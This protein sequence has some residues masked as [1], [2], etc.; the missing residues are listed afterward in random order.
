MSNIKYFQKFVVKKEDEMLK[1]NL[2]LWSYT[3]VS[4]KDQYDKNSSVERQKEAN[5]AY[6][7][8]NSYEIT[9]EFGGTYESGKSDF[10]RKEFS[11]LIEKV[12]SS[13]KRPF[14][15]LVYKMSR[16]SRTGGN[17]IGLVN[18]LVEDL[19]VHLIE[20]CSGQTT[21]TERGKINIYESLFHAHKENLEKKEI[22]IPSM[23]A[24]IKAGTWIGPCPTGYD[25][26][27]RKVKNEKFFSFKQRLVI[28]NDGALLKE[29]WQW[30]ISDMYSDA[31]IIS[32]LEA[33]GLKVSKQKLS[34][35]WRNPFYCGIIINRLIDEPVKG[36]WEPLVSEEDFIKVQ[37]L[38][39]KNTSGFQH[40]S[41]EEARPLS[42]L[43]KCNVCGC[44]MVGYKVKQKNLHYYRCLKC[45]GVSVNAATTKRAKRKGANELFFDYLK[46]Y[47]LPESLV[48]LVKMQL[49]KFFNFYN[50]GVSVNEQALKSQL[51]ALEKKLKTLKIRNGLGEIDRETFD[52]TF[53]HLSNQISNIAKE[54]NTL[55]PKISNLEKLLS[56][57]MEKLQK[58]PEIWGSGALETKRRIQK[59]LFPD[60]VYYDVKNHEYLTKRANGFLCLTSCISKGYAE[61]KN[62]TSQELLE[63][64]SE[65]PPAGLEPAT[66]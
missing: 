3:R 55:T 58:L 57:A 16:F 59:K 5:Q 18:T 45:N 64:S 26:Y 48:P 17:A 34:Q 1:P 51:D 6:A 15:I 23:V 36:N 29:A 47:V 20:V 62:W 41:E 56:L 8:E 37:T 9:E 66:L 22:V 28:N 30:K 52:L 43:L 65:A 21:I 27:G 49:I 33:R 61:N 13:R 32:K 2:F 63:K 54:M 46:K 44:F 31:Q 25:Q 11:R 12:R 50:E 19:G 60:G 7:L 38:L 14:G 35:M 39:E 53:N 4:S 42:R 10:T 24:A 40:N